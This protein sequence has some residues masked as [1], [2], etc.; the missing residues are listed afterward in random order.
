MQCNELIVVCD[1]SKAGTVLDG[2]GYAIFVHQNSV[3]ALKT[4][5]LRCF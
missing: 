5:T 4:A 3:A 1:L 2:F